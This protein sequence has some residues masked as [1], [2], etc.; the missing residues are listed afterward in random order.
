M[1]ILLVIARSWLK[2]I[3]QK[4]TIK[5]APL[6]VC[7]AHDSAV[8]RLSTLPAL[9]TQ[10]HD[11]QLAQFLSAHGNVIIHTSSDPRQYISTIEASSTA[12]SKL[13]K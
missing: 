11:I 9:W 7:P 12:V 10:Q 8:D 4:Y 13:F 6:E 1:H 3:D 5:T 2:L